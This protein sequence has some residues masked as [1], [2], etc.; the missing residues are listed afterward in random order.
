MAGTRATV[1]RCSVRRSECKEQAE[2]IDLADRRLAQSKRE[3]KPGLKV[4]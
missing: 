2:I 4:V 1:S 3:K